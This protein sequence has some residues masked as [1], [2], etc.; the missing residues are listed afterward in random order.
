MS[1]ENDRPTKILFLRFLL[2][3]NIELHMARACMEGKDQVKLSLTSRLM[4]L[5]CFSLFLSIRRL[6][7]KVLWKADDEFMNE[8]TRFDVSNVK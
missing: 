3:Q 2:R 5:L 4:G 8:P 7:L 6:H 1:S